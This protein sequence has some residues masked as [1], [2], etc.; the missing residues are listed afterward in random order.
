MGPEI[1]RAR[2]ERRDQ[3][4]IVSDLQSLLRL[5]PR[6]VHLCDDPPIPD[7]PV[8]FHAGY[9]LITT[10]EGPKPLVCSVNGEVTE[11][12]LSPGQCVLSPPGSWVLERWTT[13]H[14]HLAI[15]MQPD[16]VRV[17][18]IDVDGR[19]DASRH[20]IG[21]RLSYHTSHPP[22]V[23]AGHL[24]RAL[25]ATR[26]D[27]DV[28][29]HTLQAL[30]QSVVQQ[31]AEDSPDERRIT[32]FRWDAARAYITEN[33]DAPFTRFDVSLAVGVSQ[34]YLSRLVRRY[35]GCT[36][37]DYVGRLRHERAAHLLTHTSYS[38]REIADL[39]GFA[40]QDTFI[41]SFRRHRGTT[42]GRFRADD[43]L[44]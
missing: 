12:V 31:V 39:V 38:V 29:G 6:I 40:D 44:A 10:L 9:R 18:H 4:A 25:A 15:V 35:A 17:L 21:H 8:N 37:S 33:I 11:V 23:A 20:P 22:N 19:V 1:A 30:V 24:V 34:A 42:P 28:A 5:P 14:R 13:T 41:R 43:V 36:F 27:S 16:Y 7:F 2:V 26:R 32:S 3:G